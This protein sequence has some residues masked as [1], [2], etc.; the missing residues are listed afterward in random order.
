LFSDYPLP[1]RL[2]L[3]VNHGADVDVD[4]ELSVRLFRDFTVDG[5]DVIEFTVGGGGTVVHGW[6][7]SG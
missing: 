6:I 7:V 5:K 3:M 4:V 2:I 1:Q